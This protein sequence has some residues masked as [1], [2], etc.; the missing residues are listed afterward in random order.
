M[1]AIAFTPEIN[2]SGGLI[3]EREFETEIFVS[4]SGEEQRSAARDIPNLRLTYS[5]SA[6]DIQESGALEALIRS[7]QGQSILVPYWRGARYLQADAAIGA[8]TLLV[9]TLGAGFVNDGYALLYRD[10][11]RYEVISIAGQDPTHIFIDGVLTKTWRGAWNKDIIVPLY[12]GFLSPEV[13]L[14]YVESSMKEVSLTF[15][16]FAPPYM[17]S[18]TSPVVAGDDLTFLEDFES[19][20]KTIEMFDKWIPHDNMNVGIQWSLDPAGGVDGGQCLLARIPANSKVL[21]DGSVYAPICYRYVPVR[22]GGVY[23]FGGKIHISWASG[24]DP[25]VGLILANKNNPFFPDPVGDA[26]EPATAAAF[27]GWEEVTGS[28]TASPD[29]MT[30][31]VV[32]Y[33]AV[34][35]GT[36]SG[37]DLLV[38]FDDLHVEGTGHD[39]DAYVPPIFPVSAINAVGPMGNIVKRDVQQLTNSAGHFALYPFNSFPYG[40]HTLDLDFDSADAVQEFWDLHAATLGACKPFWLPS[41]QK[42]FDVVEPIADDDETFTFRSFGYSALLANDPARKQ[43]AFV[44]ADGSFLKRTIVSC[45]DNDDGTETATL[46]ESLGEEFDPLLAQGV[47]YMFFV[48]FDGDIGKIEWDGREGATAQIDV[49]EVRDAPSGSGDSDGIPV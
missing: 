47:C 6:M 30:G 5:V 2:W 12:E 21:A 25:V 9:D 1:P 42:E 31:E 45:I 18:P 15:D 17:A 22:P 4:D 19:Y 13:T 16:L 37:S 48:R 11:G 24:I 3:E 43:V 33:A 40:A 46:N 7:S 44:R 23:T 14:N 36:L 39:V 49:I 28:Y 35:N 34:R 27:G 41:L 20:R 32:L 26:I 10:V 29:V 38:R 8:G